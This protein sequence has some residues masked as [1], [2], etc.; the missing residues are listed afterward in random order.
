MSVAVAP[1]NGIGIL[2]VWPGARALNVPL[3][4]V[5]GTDGEITCDAS[6]EAIAKAV[7]NGASVINMSYGSPSRCAAEWVQIYFAV[8]KGIIPVA[9]AGNEFEQG[10]PLEFPASLPHVVTVAATTR[11]DKSARF[12]NAN[13]AIDLSAPGVDILTA[14][15]PALP[16][17]DR[18]PGRLL[19][20]RAGRASAPRWSRPRSPGCAPRGP[21][22]RPIAS[23]RP[24]ASA[25]ATSRRPGWDPLTGFGVLNVGNS[26]NLPADKLP[27]QDPLEPNDNIVWVDGT[28]FG[29]PRRGGLD[30]RRGLSASAAC[31]TCRRTR[32][33]STGS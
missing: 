22:S 26:L 7:Q 29:K 12:S 20:C 28:A 17:P 5:P 32:S 10:N 33:T 6:G 27:I 8:A 13:N 31:W 16:D 21:T 11:D 24:S 1:Q 4:T 23:S 18:R 25:P 19:R 14:V 3:A 30:R 15:P 2:G 9:A